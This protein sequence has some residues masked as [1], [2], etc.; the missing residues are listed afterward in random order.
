M[1]NRINTEVRSKSISSVLIITYCVMLSVFC[2]AQSLTTGLVSYWKLD[3]SSGNASDARGSN[4]LVNTNATFAAG[5]I[6]NGAKFTSTSTKLS[7]TD[8][9]QSG[10]DFSSA[11]T[12]SF[13][14]A[15][16]V[17]MPDNSAYPV[18]NKQSQSGSGTDGYEMLFYRNDMAGVTYVRGYLGTSSGNYVQFG[19]TIS[20]SDLVAGTFYFWTIVFDNSLSGSAQMK[21]YKNG[22]QLTTDWWSVTGTLTT[23][24]N[25]S[26]DFNI[27]LRGAETSFFDGTID[28]IGAWNRAL[29]STEITSL[30]N[31]GNGF[32]Y[33]FVSAA[34]VTTQAVSSIAAATATGNGNITADGGATITERGVCWNTSATPTTANSKA[35]SA[36]TTGAFTVSM[37]GLTAGALYY[38]RAYAINSVGISYGNQVTFST[39][40][41][42][43]VDWNKSNVQEITLTT[44]RAFTFTNGK[45]GGFYTLIIKQNATGNWSVTWPANIMWAS[46]TAP[47]LTSTTN[48]IDVIKFV[49]DGTNYLAITTT[50]NFH[51]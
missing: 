25:T 48:A 43:N 8:A 50:L 4:T 7:I 14:S 29:T 2:S 45:S 33:P 30:Y 35:I 49:N 19:A 6:N 23:L 44:D 47:T 38:V 5:K 11:F 22:T 41:P 32:S 10:L 9:T 1:K 36:G 26:V 21:I 12:F 27:G 24:A 17:N 16:R 28:E 51:H 42:A 39:P 13:W 46:G 3:E 40:A 31:S 18:F 34:T 37:T 20:T 15:F